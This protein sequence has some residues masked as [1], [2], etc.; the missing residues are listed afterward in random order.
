MW[1]ESL[2]EFIK[3]KNY[4]LHLEKIAYLN[5]LLKNCLDFHIFATDKAVNMIGSNTNRHIRTNYG[6]GPIT[7]I[8]YNAKLY[9][10]NPATTPNYAHKLN[11]P[12]LFTF[13]L[14]I[15]NITPKTIPIPNKPQIIYMEL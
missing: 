3:K 1:L 5:I 14:M 15:P 4:K 9:K 6:D 8:L 10:I 11:I 2:F 13:M 12:I 7:G